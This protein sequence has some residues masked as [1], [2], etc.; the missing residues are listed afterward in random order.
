M[1]RNVSLVV[2]AL[3]AVGLLSCQRA[4]EQ[5]S[6][7]SIV[8]PKSLESFN[9]AGSLE[10]V[11]AGATLCYLISVTGPNIPL[12]V[13]NTCSPPLGLLSSVVKGGDTIVLNVPRGSSRK[14]ELYL[15]LPGTDSCP[16]IT[17]PISSSLLASTYLI[18]SAK[19][20]DINSD[21]VNLTITATF[22]GLS[23]NI[24]QQLSMP[25]SCLPAA[26]SYQYLGLSVSSAQGKA[27]SADASIK[28]EA[29]IGRTQSAEV[30]TGTGYRLKVNAISQ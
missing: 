23:Q 3:T 27:I 5:D 20:V 15:H 1:K 2:L 17:A 6:S 9:K 22:P 14:F 24:A 21:T 29:R 26:P 28:M 13:P 25:A 4:I 19:N 30:L 16:E 10:A 8:T 18:G 12:A 11:P 7:I